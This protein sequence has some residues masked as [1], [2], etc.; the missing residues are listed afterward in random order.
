MLPLR[1]EVIAT[2]ASFRKTQERQLMSTAWANA[3]KASTPPSA[4]RYGC[5]VT[6]QSAGQELTSHKA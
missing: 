1:K 6:S 4:S 3:S 2:E 5:L